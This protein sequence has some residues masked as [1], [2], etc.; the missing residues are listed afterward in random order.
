MS[1]TKHTPLPWGV[2]ADE[3]GYKRN[4]E[5]PA[6]YCRKD[7]DEESTMIAETLSGFEDGTPE[8]NAQLIITSVNARPQVDELLEA[9]RDAQAVIAL[10]AHGRGL[11][12]REASTQKRLPEIHGGCGTRTYRAANH[13]LCSGESG[14]ASRTP[15]T[16]R[17]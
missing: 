11:D 1:E 13:P 10:F 6:I 16:S 9:A 17:P 5:G 12:S 15:G 8:A 4:Y 2:G 7:C 14:F 3:R